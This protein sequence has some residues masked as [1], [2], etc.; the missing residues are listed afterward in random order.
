MVRVLFTTSEIYPVIKVGG[1]A[2]VSNSLT[3]AL[4]S[5]RLRVH[6]LLP[7]YRSVMRW[8]QSTNA[9]CVVRTDM[10]GQPVTLWETVVPGSPV[11]LWVIDNP[12]LFDRSG[13]PYQDEHGH[14]W[15]DNDRRFAFYAR[16]AAAIAMDRLGLGWRPDVVHCNDWPSG[17][18]PALLSLEK[19]RPA[20]VFTIHNLAHRGLF[21]AETV[22]KL[23]L[24]GELWCMAGLEFYGQLAFIKGG[25]AYA[26]QL[27]TV[28]PTYAREIQT[29]G[30]G[31]GMDG[32]L[33]YRRQ[34]L[35]G[36]LNGIDTR[37]WDPKTDPYLSGHYDRLTLEQKKACKQSLQDALGLA[38]DPGRPLLGFIGRLVHQKGVDL[39]MENLPR[40]MESGCNVV[41]L[42]SGDRATEHRLTSLASHYP[43]RLAIRI[44]FDE[45]LAHQITAGVDMF[46]M[47]SRF[48]P[49]GLNQMYSLH[50]GSVPIVRKVGG[51]RDTVF[52]PANVSEDRANG[53]SFT[54]STP[55]SFWSALARC[56]AAFHDKKQ[57]Q[58]LQANGMIQDFSWDT[59]ARK[60]LRVYARA[61]NPA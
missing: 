21:P 40:L 23:N 27:T 60:Y 42:G 17:L 9:T 2:D 61:R 6:V 11:V 48:E 1:L 3:R 31:H 46:M 57:W 35:S 26:D 38:P 32:L 30:E 12:G 10:D 39:I 7:G 29:T 4:C 25:L 13:G 49:C 53:F 5:K 19:N 52:D 8:M 45:A 18:I 33:R 14:D 51:L 54:E 36:I 34:R 58:Q 47:P 37:E 44:G 28:S 55:E 24:P 20:T 43:G 15:H 41:I 22:E 59:S 50:Y 56:L 16:V